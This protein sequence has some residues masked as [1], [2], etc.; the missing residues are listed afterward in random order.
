MTAEAGGA[1]ATARRALS[2]LARSTAAALEDAASR[3]RDDG[4]VAR[5]FAGDLRALDVGS[6]PFRS[7]PGRATRGLAHASAVLGAMNGG[8]GAAARAAFGFVNWTEFYAEDDWSRPFLDRFANGEGIG[9]DGMLVSEELIL[10]LFILGPGAFY[11]AHAHPAEEFYI[12]LSG[13]PSFQ[14]GA[15]S[16]FLARPPGSAVL[17]QS[18]QSHAIQAGETPLF[19]VF[20]WRGEIDAPSWYRADMTDPESPL[21]RPTIRKA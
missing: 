16:E 11:P 10:G 6:L 19:A 5:R 2:A 14:V 17:H 20:G 8:L 12:V 9:P 15:G 7:R 1:E 13:T 3:A 18:D 21:F 4:A